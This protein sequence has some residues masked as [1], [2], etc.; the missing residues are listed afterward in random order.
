MLEAR[1]QRLL[2]VF[3]LALAIASICFGEE[4]ATAGGKLHHRIALTLEG[5]GALGIAHIGVLKVLEKIGVP[6]DIVTG[7][8]MGALVGG[9]YSMGY[10][11][12]QLEA[13]VR[14][15][16]WGELFAEDSRRENR[17]ILSDMSDARYFAE[18]EFDKAGFKSRGGLL[19]GRNILDAFDRLTLGVPYD[20]NFD[21]LPIRYRAVATDLESGAA[22]AFSRG[23]L[24]DA[25]RASMSFPAI[26]APYSV[27]GRYYVDGGVVNNLP[28]DVA[29]DMGA[30]VVIAVQLKG[31]NPYDPEKVNRS[32]FDSVARSLDQVTQ[33]NTKAQMAR[34][35]F[36]ITVDLEGYQITDFAKGDEILAL[37][38]KAARASAP[39]LRSFLAALGDLDAPRRRSVEAEPIARVLVEGAV[40]ERDRNEAI[41]IYSGV[42]G[43]A[44]Y[45][46]YLESA[47][48]KLGARCGHDYVRL[49]AEDSSAGRTLVVSLTK[50]PDLGNSL[51]LGLAYSGYYTGSISNK[52]VV[53]PGIVLRGFPAEDSELQVE[54]TTFENPGIQI[55]FIQPFLEYIDFRA[56]LSGMSGYDTYYNTGAANYQYQT[57]AASGGVF[58]ET[59]YLANELLSLGW[60][61][62]LLS[63]D[64]ISMIYSSPTVKHASLLLLSSEYRRLD[65]PVL[66]TSGLLLKTDYA[67]SLENLGSERF[68]QSLLGKCGF[69][70]PV[71]GIHSLGVKGIM[72]TD[73]SWGSK[74]DVSAPLHYKP[75]LSDRILF[76]APLAIEETMGA[77]VAGGG[78]DLKFALR[79]PSGLVKIPIFAIITAAAGTALQNKETYEI[80]GIPY[81]ANASLG[82]GVRLGD[83]FGVFLRGG[84]NRNSDGEF[85]P[86]FAADIGA[87]PL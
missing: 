67:L 11:A 42:V 22:V 43:L 44:D 27:N 46:P 5:G 77:F 74:E 30:D 40:S 59:G 53:T 39:E 61:N 38:E 73:F 86:F 34:A 54:A 29:K 23:N 13:I 70:F 25:M 66:T 47:Y 85:K 76:P 1:M 7:T 56:S 49:R 62:D 58:L 68:F 64:D 72:G 20:V 21:E 69:Y 2:V 55:D 17:T 14:R 6:V 84:V 31:G 79:A 82:L 28:V 41:K 71:G 63:A 65:H 26:F 18:L 83:A 15:M 48:R 57:Q 8:S 81:H 52:L 60:R 80:D 19:E 10:D 45:G 75:E 33:A 36:V 78:L 37:G 32:P 50:K 87:I 16:D 9:L 3:L 35:D 24:A 51:R 12:E 4:P